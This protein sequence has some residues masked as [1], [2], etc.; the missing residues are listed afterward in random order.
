MP[1]PASAIRTLLDRVR[2]RWRWWLVF[3]A[4]TRSAIAAAGLLGMALWL[5]GWT[6]GAPGALALL[7]VL[8]VVLIAAAIVWGAWPAREV[9]TD[10]RVARFIEEHHPSLDDRLVSA[11]DLLASDDPDGRTALAGPMI[12][13]ASGNHTEVELIAHNCAGTSANC[14]MNAVAIPFRELETGG[15]NGCLD[16][17]PAVLRQAHRLFEQTRAIVAQH[18]PLIVTQPEV[19]L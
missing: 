2:S 15:R 16:N 18:L 3:Q 5:A 19:Q 11:V 6:S 8:A 13:V 12:T 14:G 1:P 9:P 17:A 4:T 10:S 7:A